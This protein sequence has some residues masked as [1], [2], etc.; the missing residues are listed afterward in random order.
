MVESIIS[1]ASD[2]RSNTRLLLLSRDIT[3]I[4]DVI[5]S[6]YVRLDVAAQSEDLKLYVAA[7][8][9]IRRK[10]VGRGRLRIRNPDLKEHIAKTLVEG[11][12]VMLVNPIVFVDMY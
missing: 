4:R 10:R 1:L 11:A 5:S 3:E 6:D 2:D 8:I 12:A 7:E 9:D